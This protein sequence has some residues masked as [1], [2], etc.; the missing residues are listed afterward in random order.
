MRFVIALL[1]LV[2]IALPATAQDTPSEEEDKSRLESWLQDT[3]S[4]AGRDVTVTGFRGALSS[5]ATMQRLEIA[6]DDGIWLTLTDITLDWTRSAVLDR[7]IEINRLTAAEIE[8]ARLPGGD[9]EAAPVPETEASDFTLPELPVA[10]RIGEI[11]TESLKLGAPVLGEEVEMRLDGSAALANGEGS[12]DF[13]LTRIDGKDGAFTLSGSFSNETELLDLDLVLSEGEGGIAATVLGLP[14]APAIDLV[15]EGSDPISDFM[16]NIVLSTDGEDR[17]AG[18]VELAVDRPETET[19]QTGSQMQL[20]ANI[21]GD[22]RP[23]FEEDYQR[24]FGGES[25]LHLEAA[26]FPNGA[27]QVGDLF[28]RTDA[29]ELR[30]NAALNAE[31]WPENADITGTLASADGTPVVLPVSG[32][33]STLARA[34]ISFDYDTLRDSGWTANVAASDFVRD[35]TR[36]G[37]VTLSGAG[38]LEPGGGD[39]PPSVDG[40]ITM[41]ATDLKPR[42]AALAQA[43]GPALSGGFAFSRGSGTPLQISDLALSGA[44]YGLTGAITLDTVVEQLDLLADLDLNLSAENLARFADLAGQDIAGAADVSI[45]GNVAVP[46]GPFD[47][48]IDGTTQDF[49]LGIDRIDG[50]FSGQNRIFVAAERDE[51]GTTIREA[52]LTGAGV[53][54]IASGTLASDASRIALDL[55]LPDGTRL[56]PQLVGAVTADITAVSAAGDWTVDGT[57]T[58]PGGLTARFDGTAQSTDDGF[59]P[60]TAQ[61]VAAA[62][63]FA[64]YSGL[65]GRSLAGGGDVT[66]RVAGDLRSEALTLS[67]DAETR[68]L[69]LA[70][71]NL[72]QL[73]RGTANVALTARR[74]EDGTLFVD[75]LDLSTPVV[76]ATATGSGSGDQSEVQFDARLAD[77]GIFVPNLGG[78]FSAGG[79]AILTGEDYRIDISGSGPAGLSVNVD[80]T[81][82]GDASRANLSLNGDMPLALANGFISGAELSGRA[83]FDLALNGP[84][85][86]GSLSGRVTTSTLRAAVPSAAVA[87]GPVQANVTLGNGQARIEAAGAVSSGGRVE[88]AGPV[89]LSRGYDAGLT[90]RLDNVGLTDPSLYDTQVNG[91]LT[92]QGPLT[93][94]ARIAGTLNTGLV[95]IR[96]PS[97]G[98]AFNGNVDG[99]VHVNEPRAVRA[100]RGFANKV[101]TGGRTGG[102]AGVAYP[103]DIVIN[104]PNQVFIRGR[105]LDAELGGSLVIGGTTANV[106]PQGGLS[107]IRGRLDL[108]GNRLD[109]TE[110]SATLQGDFDPFIQVAAVTNVEDVSIRIAIDG[111]ASNPEVSFTSSPD[112]PEDEILARLVFG[113]SVAEISP[114]QALRLANGVATLS[115]RSGGGVMGNIRGGLGL[116]DLDVASDEEGNLGVTAGAYISDNIYTGVQVGAD[117]QAEVTINLDVTDNLTARGSVGTDGNTSLGIYF[118]RD[119]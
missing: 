68:N 70:L 64:P 8:L 117:G 14:G 15:V 34:E 27:I 51:T 94:G 4:G 65:A 89:G 106:V 118:E 49:D 31:G 17:L 83:A 77:I 75:N 2:A 28:L 72:D 46:G 6:D 26:R 81:V 33:R 79:T 5:E 43:I 24:F 62:E 113:R 61:V 47:I 98:F 19:E 88:V 16:A 20:T 80:G 9:D 38:T 92:V 119:Y 60:V 23:L 66:A 30:G 103:L 39:T 1:A 95:E 114:L 7:R 18:Q 35:G 41:Q 82:A 45:T 54:A 91:Q 99:L 22:L 53:T 93:G 87:L 44:D 97:S 107:L 36:V 10:I 69:S 110:A 59:G 84:L 29:L 56:D 13:G 104:A 55:D 108:L 25:L 57:A 58:G 42:E 100:T 3:L 76:T 109:L 111:P 67:L 101:E 37:E 90:I 40:R 112:L 52:R 48:E 21:A 32:P 102:G 105:G 71:G 73:L 74:D 86:L 116:A 96:I 50:L 85:E 63:S 115:G 11:S 78:A 12:A